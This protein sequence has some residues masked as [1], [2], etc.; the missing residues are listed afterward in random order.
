MKTDYNKE[1]EKMQQ[2]II[3]NNQDADLALVNL[4]ASKAGRVPSDKKKIH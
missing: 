1:N 2:L 4:I 3:Q